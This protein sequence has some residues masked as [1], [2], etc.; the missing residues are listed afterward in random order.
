MGTKTIGNT[1]GLREAKPIEVDV[2]NNES[3]AFVLGLALNSPPRNQ[4][5]VKALRVPRECGLAQEVQYPTSPR[6]A[7]P[8]HHITHT[9]N[10]ASGPTAG[11]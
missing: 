7:L 11:A 2:D 4:H 8:R 9:I 1:V 3:F 6:M 5:S 10:M